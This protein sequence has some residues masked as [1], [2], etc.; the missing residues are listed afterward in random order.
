MV[1]LHITGAL[2]LFAALGLEW[3]GTN[4]LRRSASATQAREWMKLMCSVG[5]LQGPSL[6]LIQGAG[7]YMMHVMGGME[8]RPWMGLGL[9]GLIVIGLAVGL[10][11]PASSPPPALR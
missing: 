3:A 2:G 6:L 11:P 7:L 5:W 4:N 8:G 10:T 1:F 9:I